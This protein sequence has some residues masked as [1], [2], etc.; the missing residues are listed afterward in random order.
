MVNAED[1]KQELEGAIWFVNHQIQILSNML[2]DDIPLP[3]KTTLASIKDEL[4]KHVK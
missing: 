2:G 1:R 3:V 4:R